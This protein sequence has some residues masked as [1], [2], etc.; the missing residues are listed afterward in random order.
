MVE[1]GRAGPGMDS[2]AFSQESRREAGMAPTSSLTIAEQEQFLEYDEI[3]EQVA[4]GVRLMTGPRSGPLRA[5]HHH[6]NPT[7]S[8]LPQST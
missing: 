3:D 4:S 5:N 8:H 1:N 6:Q 7:N 2:Q